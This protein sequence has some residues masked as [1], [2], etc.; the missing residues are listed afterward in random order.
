MTLE[1]TGDDWRWAEML[2]MGVRMQLVLMEISRK[3]IST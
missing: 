2:E 3:L 1:M